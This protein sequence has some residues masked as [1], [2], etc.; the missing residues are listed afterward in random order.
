M[1]QQIGA[2]KNFCYK[3]FEISRKSFLGLGSF[4]TVFRAKCDQMPC[5][6]K[7]FH[8]NVVDP[9]DSEVKQKLEEVFML[10]KINHPNL[11]QYLGVENDGEDSVLLMEVIDENLTMFLLNKGSVQLPFHTQVD[12]SH[13]ISLGLAYLHMNDIIHQ[14]LTSNNVLVV[15]GRRAK[16]SDYGMTILNHVALRPVGREVTYTPPEAFFSQKEVR[17]TAKYDTYSFGALLIQICTRQL[18][19]PAPATKTVKDRRYPMGEI[20]IHVPETERRKAQLS[21]VDSDHPFLSIINKCLCVIEADRPSAAEICEELQ[22]MKEKQQ[23]QANKSGLFSNEVSK[24]KE[25]ELQDLL[26]EAKEEAKRAM[27][28]V[29]S[30]EDEIRLLQKQLDDDHKLR[31]DL[32]HD[33]D[34]VIMHREQ[35]LQEQIA[36]REKM[37]IDFQRTIK[38]LSTEIESLTE[39]LLWYRESEENSQDG[40]VPQNTING[41][42]QHSSPMVQNP[43]EVSPE[44]QEQTKDSAP[45]ITRS[46]L[47]PQNT[48]Y[49]VVTL[50]QPL[51]TTTQLYQPWQTDA[52]DQV[53]M[54]TRIQ[55]EIKFQG[56]MET[57]L[58]GDQQSEEERQQEKALLFN[59]VKYIGTPPESVDDQLSVQESDKIEMI[60]RDGENAPRSIMRGSSVVDGNI[61]YYS[62]GTTIISYDSDNEEWS[63]LQTNALRFSSL[64]MV[65]GLL[66]TIGGRL[67]STRETTD[68]LLSLV[69]E[70]G[71]HK[72]VETF[73]PMPTKRCYTVTANTGKELVVAG[74]SVTGQPEEGTTVVEVMDIQS[75]TW[76][77]A[78][79]LPMPITNGSMSI[80][81]EDVCIVGGKTIFTLTLEAFANSFSH[82]KSLTER[83]KRSITLSLSLTPPPGEVW[84][85]RADIPVHRTTCASV[86]GQLLAVGGVESE[87]KVSAAI[88]K[89]DRDSDCWEVITH[90]AVPRYNCHTAVLSSNELM[91]VGGCT[92]THHLTNSVEIAQVL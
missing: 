55:D 10:K 79:S 24:V 53:E 35:L 33:K 86:N 83:L 70:L 48:P 85:R 5:V 30:K 66:T 63:I 73:P 50:Q 27:E 71:T 64:E 8:P 69:N 1:A 58:L 22:Q 62:Y 65:Q 57:P 37:E 88:Y 56:L 6:A 21:F 25:R 68:K 9:S 76:C 12:L 20:Q 38:N 31:N 39:R 13:D 47:S 28:W 72:W 52:E 16:V 87:G 11:V 17:V 34:S 40:D 49:N 91:V 4:G 32:L 61:A 19:E 60:M 59:Q 84:T 82:Q 45:N 3:N 78:I 7:V 80:C 90:M 2:S 42:E 51:L 44:S 54:E 18:T 43:S 89:Y 15:A 92:R 77:T 14:N 74:G 26:K 81:G 46:E 36:V 67:S 75:L 29:R 41:S 23:Y